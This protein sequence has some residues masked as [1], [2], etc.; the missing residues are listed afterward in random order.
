MASYTGFAVYNQA[1]GTYIQPGANDT[2]TILGNVVISKDLSVNG[3]FITNQSEEVLIQD[4]YLDLNFGYTTASGK[5][6]GFTVNYLPTAVA[7][8]IAAGGFPAG[9][10][11][12]TVADSAAFAAGD[13][14]MVSG[15]ADA[16]NNGIYEVASQNAGVITIDSTPVESFCKNAFDP[17][18]TVQ[19]AVTKINVA[20]LQVNGSTGN[21]EIGRGATVPIT[22]DTV[23]TSAS[24]TVLA[25]NVQTGAVNQNASFA[26]QG[27][28]STT[29]TSANA[30][31]TAVVI[32]SSNAAGGV[33]I[34][35]GTGG[36]DI[37]I[38]QGGSGTGDG[39]LTVNAGAASTIGTAVGELT[40]TAS[41]AAGGVTINA[42]T[43]GVDID[44]T[45]AGSGSGDGAFNVNAA[46]A[47]SIAT[48]T[49][50]LT[51][52]ATNAAGG[53]TINS[54]TGGIDLDATNAGSGSGD[55]SVTINAADDSAID[56]AGG[57][58]ALSTT[59][60]GTL[61]AISSGALTLTGAA[62]STWSTSGT[63][64]LNI[65]GGN[66]LNLQE[67]GNTYISLS[68]TGG[69]TVDSASNQDVVLKAEGQNHFVLNA[70][71]NTTV[72]EKSI[73]FPGT[74]TAG[75]ATNTSIPNVQMGSGAAITQWH[76]LAMDSDGQVLPADC[77]SGTA[78]LKNPIG[79]AVAPVG[80]AGAA[81]PVCTFGAMVQI[82]AKGTPFTNTATDAGKFVY[83][84]DTAG[85]V[86]LAAPTAGRTYKVGIVQTVLSTSTAWIIFQP[87]FII[88]N[89]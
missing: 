65:S 37:D 3:T 36:V 77:D 87:Q 75:A 51:L 74:N 10:V 89:S 16:S 54:G 68:G 71:T 6:G 52:A 2:S 63:A 1:T 57:N 19:G 31:A 4:N 18:A 28:G 70:T 14:I 24:G 79:I 8:N 11:T 67:G 29:I 22:Y 49:G 83:L 64:V 15:A 23:S 27:N 7:S 72:A 60:S 12:V 46:S 5:D 66:G 43:G 25:N 81:V 44:V 82:V 39:A 85:L 62:T 35:G 88:D 30:A 48:A 76:V 78:A 13:I 40:L 26:T 38:T 42:G 59:T 47:S 20:V 56:V 9:N 50:E 86:D 69:V 41:N 32:S 73:T 61:S 17:D 53:V 84:S 21:W 80:G 34:N 58:L 33:Q 45:A 55:G